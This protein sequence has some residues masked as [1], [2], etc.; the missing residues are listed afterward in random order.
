MARPTTRQQTLEETRDET[1]TQQEEGPQEDAPR[2][3][4][5]ASV[6]G[7]RDS[8]LHDTEDA[9]VILIK[10][11]MGYS[12]SDL[13]ELMEETDVRDVKETVTWITEGF[14]KQ[15]TTVERL[16]GLVKQ[17]KQQLK[18]KDCD[19]NLARREVERI[20]IAESTPER[21]SPRQPRDSSRSEKLPD[22]PVFKGGSTTEWR[23]FHDK[24]VDK[25]TINQDRYPTEHSQIGYLKSRLESEPLELVI[26]HQSTNPDVTVVE[27]IKGLQ[28]RYADH[29]AELTA[30]E[31]YRTLYQRNQPFE[32]F[33]GNFQRV[34]AEARV[35]SK[36]Q[37][38]DLYGRLSS[39]L[40]AAAIMVKA[41]S[42]STM[43]KDLRLVARRDEQAQASRKK[44]QIMRSRDKTSADDKETSPKRESS[45]GVYRGGDLTNIKCFNCGK[46]GH[47]APKCPDKPISGN[48][49]PAAK[50]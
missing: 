49:E 13:K 24:L 6:T 40:Q 46:K 32:E 9:R 38:Q 30:R 26:T 11:I 21:D 25:L 29:F 45:S 18:D 1:Q 41:D 48:G 42:L 50:T 27:L 10:R 47:I 37:A 28:E 3:G 20:E 15:E 14:M 16:T 36:T 43:I 12:E 5:M 4:S 31:T 44:R 7:R 34:A 35:D 39:N 22:P 19:L 17:L 23:H 2:S 8:M 33:I